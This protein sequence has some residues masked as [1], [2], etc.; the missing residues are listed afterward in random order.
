[1]QIQMMESQLEAEKQMSELQQE[2]NNNAQNHNAA[3]QKLQ[4][5]NDEKM[6]KLQGVIGKLS[7]KNLYRL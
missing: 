2:L 5:E 7:N 1:M 3:M 6:R 4:R